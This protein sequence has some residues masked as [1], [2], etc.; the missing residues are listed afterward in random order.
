VDCDGDR[1]K[2]RHHSFTRIGVDTSI[3]QLQLM[4]ESCSGTEESIRGA[5]ITYTTIES[6]R[7]THTLSLFVRER[8]RAA[9]SLHLLV[10][11]TI[12]IIIIIIIII[13]QPYHQKASYERATT[14]T[15]FGRYA[16]TKAPSHYTIVPPC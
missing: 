14:D 13:K 5:I 7:H 12:P 8:S 10:N 6:E 2:K 9:R 3:I 15:D 1:K 4:M 16:L 11:D